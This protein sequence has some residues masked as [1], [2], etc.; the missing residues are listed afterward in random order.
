MVR[1]LFPALCA[2]CAYLNDDQ[3]ELALQQEEEA[4][5]NAIRGV[6]RLHTKHFF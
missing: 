1:I 3:C 5:A 2:S 4:L 6:P